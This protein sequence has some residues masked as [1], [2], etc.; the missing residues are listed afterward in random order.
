MDF[1]LFVLIFFDLVMLDII[2]VVMWMD[3]CFI[4]LL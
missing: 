1:G 3:L 2:C 4:V